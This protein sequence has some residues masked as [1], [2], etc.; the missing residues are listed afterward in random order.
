MHLLTSCMGDVKVKISLCEID[1][2]IF[3]CFSR[4]FFWVI[5]AHVTVKESLFLMSFIALG[6]KGRCKWELE[7]KRKILHGKENQRLG[8]FSTW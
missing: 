7:E 5:Q 2:F 1:L 6:Y 3:F 4:L 8:T